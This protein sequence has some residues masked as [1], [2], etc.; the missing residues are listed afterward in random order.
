[1]SEPDDDVERRASR[2]LLYFSSVVYCGFRISRKFVAVGLGI[3]K[4]LGRIEE[5]S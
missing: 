5:K 1:M 3:E 2:S 4:E